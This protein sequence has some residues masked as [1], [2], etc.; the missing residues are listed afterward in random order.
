MLRTTLTFPLLLLSCQCL[1]DILDIVMDPHN[2]N[3]ETSETF[4]LPLPNLPLLCSCLVLQ[5]KKDISLQQ[6]LCCTFNTSC[7]ASSSLLWISWLLLC[8]ALATNQQEPDLLLP[9]HNNWTWAQRQTTEV[10]SRGKEVLS[11]IRKQMI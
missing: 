10:T 7:V 3:S 1:R 11:V 4:L 8:E 5:Y 6:I 9:K 2:P